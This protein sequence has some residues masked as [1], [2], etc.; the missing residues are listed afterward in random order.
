MYTLSFKYNYT[1]KNDLHNSV[2]TES[3]NS[4]LC[5]MKYTPIIICSL[6]L[7]WSIDAIKKAGRFFRILVLEHLPSI[8]SHNE[9]RMQ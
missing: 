2:F 6:Q 3:V 5:I 1:R 8:I 9:S 4:Y 7:F